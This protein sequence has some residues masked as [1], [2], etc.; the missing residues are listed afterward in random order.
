MIRKRMKQK[1]K[2]IFS[3]KNERSVEKKSQTKMDKDKKKER[4]IK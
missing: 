4:K 1:K 2:K 3:S